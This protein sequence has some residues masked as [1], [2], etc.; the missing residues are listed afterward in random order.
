MRLQNYILHIKLKSV[1]ILVSLIPLMLCDGIIN[2]L[3]LSSS[4]IVFLWIADIFFICVLYF[5]YR[6]LPSLMMI[7][8]YIIYITIII[9]SVINGS[10]K[11]TLNSLVSSLAMCMIFDLWLSVK[12]ETFLKLLRN[13]LGMLVIANFLTVI[14]FPNGIYSTYIYPVNWLLGHKNTHMT[15][16]LMAVAIEAVWTYKK[17]NCISRISIVYMMMCSLSLYLVDAATAFVV[18]F[19]YTI[20][21]LLLFSHYNN[22]VI[23]WIVSRINLSIILF[24]AMVIEVE[25]VF[26]QNNNFIGR[27]CSNIL[28]LLGR[29]ISFTGRT[30]IWD[31]SLDI[32]KQHLFVGQGVVDSI[33]FAHITK[34]E[35]GT[36]AHNYLLN[37]LI[38]GGVICA[39]EHCFLYLFSIRMIVNKKSYYAYS[40]GLIIALYFISGITAVNFYSILFNAVFVLF[41]HVVSKEESNKIHIGTRKFRLI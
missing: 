35:A 16:I 14:I 36:H 19:L 1:V 10:P 34:L 25:L 13:T 11:T 23:H 20:I 12:Y 9:A 37:I 15:Y 40:L 31:A 28:P 8:L 30:V 6:Q 38:M 29:D 33:L 26:I 41:Y 24:L 21:I 39:I 4:F 7:I 22:R 2:I 5:L 27:L 18:V 3:N 17:N 32:I